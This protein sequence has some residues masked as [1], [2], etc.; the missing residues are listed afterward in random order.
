MN[1]FIDTNVFLDVFH[2]RLPFYEAS[3]VLLG[4][5]ETG[6]H[7]GYMNLI[8]LANIHYISAKTIGKE[9]SIS[10]LKT[11]L[12]FILITK[13]NS[14]LAKRAIYSEFHD[15]EDAL[16]HFSAATIENIDAIITRDLN[17]FKLSDIPVY[18]PA[19]FLKLNP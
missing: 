13:A 7:N 2:Q 16:Q 10:N 14:D 4:K 3:S 9:E 18:T 5:C 6:A 8:S 17:D 12:S 19:E 11:L 1:I 15:L